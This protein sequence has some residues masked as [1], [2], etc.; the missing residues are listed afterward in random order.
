MVDFEWEGAFEVRQVD[1]RFVVPRT[2]RYTRHI[3][4]SFRQVGGRTGTMVMT[5]GR[6]LEVYRQ[7]DRRLA[8][9]TYSLRQ[10]RGGEG[11]KRVLRLRLS[12][13]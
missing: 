11:G 12:A 13:R 4:H 8:V 6:E 2:V 1:R 7:V 3:D 9:H 5:N 10:V